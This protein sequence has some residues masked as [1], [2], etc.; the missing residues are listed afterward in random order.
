MRLHV[1]K[2]T[3]SYTCTSAQGPRTRGQRCGTSV[4]STSSALQ[5]SPPSTAED[6][7]PSASV[8]TRATCQHRANPN[9]ALAP[10]SLMQCVHI[11][12]GS[13]PHGDSLSCL[14][15]HLSC[16]L[17]HLWCDVA[18]QREPAPCPSL[19]LILTGHCPVGVTTL[20]LGGS[21]LSLTSTLGDLHLHLH[22]AD[23][24]PRRSP[25]PSR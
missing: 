15:S 2:S 23:L 1:R 16:R 24:Y 4:A 17:S 7:T 18:R 12:A 25:S 5:R 8:R 11:A 3:C 21:I 9:L 14:L 19:H 13:I 10:P 20:A 22:L 6:R